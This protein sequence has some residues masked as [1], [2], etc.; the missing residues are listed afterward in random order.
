MVARSK[1]ATVGILLLCSLVA[2]MATTEEQI[3]IVQLEA[4]KEAM[5]RRLMVLEQAFAQAQQLPPD[6][7]PQQQHPPTA[8]V[9][10]WTRG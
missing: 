2:V 4:D 3:R 10:W 6:P 7:P 9:R 8:G 5:V 1:V